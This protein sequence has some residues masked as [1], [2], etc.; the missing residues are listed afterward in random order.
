MF[1]GFP[2]KL[3]L[4]KCIEYLLIFKKKKK[5][6]EKEKKETKKNTGHTV[7]KFLLNVSCMW[8]F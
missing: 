7:A 4:V 8:S 5:K 6:K 3:I 2:H 1:V